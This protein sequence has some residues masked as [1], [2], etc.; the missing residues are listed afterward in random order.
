MDVTK[1]SDWETLWEAAEKF[2]DGKINVLV[3]N[4]GVNHLV[5][6]D[7]CMEINLNGVLLGSNMFQEKKGKINGGPGGLVVNTASM[8]GVLCGFDYNA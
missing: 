7:L 6:F 8:A 2:F 1:K 4:A 5:G 3:N